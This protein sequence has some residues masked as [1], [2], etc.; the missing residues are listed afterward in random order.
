MFP[1][2]GTRPHPGVEAARMPWFRRPWII[3]AALACCPP[4]GLYLT[5]RYSAWDRTTRWLATAILGLVL[6][7]ALTPFP[8]SATPSGACGEHYSSATPYG[9]GY[10]DDDDDDDDEAYEQ[11]EPVHAGV[12]VHYGGPY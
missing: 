11:C 3:V 8:G 4:L 10:D 1:A 9:T 12:G 6:F 7:S 2:D 5:W